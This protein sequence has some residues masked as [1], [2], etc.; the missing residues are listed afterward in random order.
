[1]KIQSAKAK[2]RRLQQ[3]IVN[4]ILHL[5]PELQPDD[6]RSTSMGA[7]GE[8]IQLSPAARS[9]FPYSIEAKNQERLNI[10]S[11]IEQ[12]GQNAKNFTALTVFKKNNTPSYVALPWNHFLELL[13]AIKV[14]PTLTTMDT[15]NTEDCDRAAIVKDVIKYLESLL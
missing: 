15:M 11:A 1:M 9:L 3:Q 7:Q 6:V 10:W 14:A 12:N 13:K 4:D 8:D 2:G 5:H